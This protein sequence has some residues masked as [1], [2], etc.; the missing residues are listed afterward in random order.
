MEEDVEEDDDD[1][2][3]DEEEE[4]IAPCTNLGLV[5]WSPIIMYIENYNYN[6]II[7]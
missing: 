1:E 2:D 4:L 7:K 5:P 3:E 6:L